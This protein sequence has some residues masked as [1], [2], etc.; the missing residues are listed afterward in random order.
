MTRNQKAEN[1]RLEKMPREYL[2]SRN[3]HIRVG[4]QYQA[5]IPE[6]FVTK[7][8][9]PPRKRVLEQSGALTNTT[10]VESQPRKKITITEQDFA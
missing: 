1:P 6:M 7:D 5:Q 3:S 4:S 10:E 8:E 2:T 9:A